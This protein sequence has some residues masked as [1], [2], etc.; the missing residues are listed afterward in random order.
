LQDREIELAID[1]ARGQWQEILAI[2]QKAESEIVADLAPLGSRKKSIRARLDDLEF[3]QKALIVTAR[4]DGV[5]VS[6]GLAEQVGKWLP[7]GQSLGLIVDPQNFRFSAVVLQDE[8][9]NLFID[10]MHKGEVR[11]YGQ[12]ERIVAV[13]SV[14]IVPFQQGTLPSSV[15]G[16]RGGGEVAVS[17]SEASGL[18]TEEPFFQ[19]YAEL[20]SNSEAL[21]FHG[22]SGKLRFSLSPEPLLRQWT[23]KLHQLVQKRYKI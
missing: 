6:P 14:Q 13:K 22:C 12:T 9:S 1:E 17:M 3:R 18:Q 5:W 16:W 2:E 20:A 10:R 7:R 15:L 21:L 23:R 4:Q 19:I 11:L 8:A